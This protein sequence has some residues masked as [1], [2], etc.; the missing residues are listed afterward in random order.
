[1]PVFHRSRRRANAGDSAALNLLLIFVLA[2]IFTAFAM[3]A[4]RSYNLREHTKLARIVLLDAATQFKEWRKTHPD[5]RPRSFED[6][7]FPSTAVYVLSDGT[8]R[9]S[10]N[11]NSI[12][13]VSLAPPDATPGQSCGLQ[14]AGDQTGFILLAEPVQTQR[15]E[16]QCTRLCI[17]STG[18]KGVTGIAGVAQCWGGG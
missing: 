15:I 10:A 1:M 4:Y 17:A 3:P 2:V 13:R 5:R 16:T 9:P 6:L 12:Y 8:T 7:G 11:I 18:Q 14:L